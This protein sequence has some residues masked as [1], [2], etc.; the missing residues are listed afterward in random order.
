LAETRCLGLAGGEAFALGQ[1]GVPGLA[2]D[3][4][5]VRQFVPTGDEGRPGLPRFV[6]FLDEEP[7]QRQADRQGRL[8]IAPVGCGAGGGMVASGVSMALV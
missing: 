1:E 4:R 6:Q 8:K 7:G 3:G 5:G 2:L